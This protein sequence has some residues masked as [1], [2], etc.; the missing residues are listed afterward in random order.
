LIPRFVYLAQN[1]ELD[2][3]KEGVWAISN[4]TAGGSHD[5]IMYVVL[6]LMISLCYYALLSIDHIK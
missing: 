1:N 5:Q 6:V 3:K 4:V 2:L